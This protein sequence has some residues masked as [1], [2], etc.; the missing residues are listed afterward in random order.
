MGPDATLFR[1]APGQQVRRE[2]N[3]L[4]VLLAGVDLGAPL[5]AL[6]GDCVVVLA[7]RGALPIP[8]AEARARALLSQGAHVV[9]GR[10][11]G[12]SVPVE[13]SDGRVLAL[14]LGP[15]LSGEDG[16][17]QVLGATCTKEE[18]RARVVPVRVAEGVP[19]LDL[20]RLAA[21]LGLPR[22]FSPDPGN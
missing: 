22:T 10:G 11:F 4:H 15:F 6:A 2:V 3:G 7:S 21:E 8:E 9:V 5:P 16:E 12:A 17:G 20:D 14:S 1:L 13:L 18:V 19:A